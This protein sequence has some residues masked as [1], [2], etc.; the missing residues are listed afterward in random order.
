L[1]AR[2]LLAKTGEALDS[3]SPL[4]ARA[5]KGVS[6]PHGDKTVELVAYFAGAM[7]LPNAH[8]Y[9]SAK[10]GPTCI[11]ASS[12]PPS[13]VLGEALASHPNERARAFLVLRALKLA[14]SKAAALARTQAAELV[15]LVSAWLKAFNPTWQ[16]QGVNVAALNAIGG[17]VQAAL[18]RHLD[19]DVGVIALEVAGG[20]GTQTAMLGPAALA[21]ANR[22][23]LL[24]LGDPNAALDGIAMSHG[25]LDGAPREAAQRAAW[26]AKTPEAKDVVAFS[27]ADAYAEARVRL[28]LD[29]T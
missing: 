22:T 2:A 8:V 10:L 17:R 26:I 24:A 15:V 13:L 25:A 7:G 28:G 1:S 19:P 3:A 11:P 23:S 14:Q 4:D 18:P 9:V 20:M 16:P 27:V 12:S 29:R 5:L 21:W 6:P